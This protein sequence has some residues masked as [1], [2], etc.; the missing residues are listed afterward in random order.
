MFGRDIQ[1][2]L[3]TISFAIT[4]SSK[5]LFENEQKCLPDLKCYL[6]TDFVTNHS[7]M[8]ILS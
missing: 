3:M 4:A 5:L 8:C 1:E 7:D 2:C 6:L